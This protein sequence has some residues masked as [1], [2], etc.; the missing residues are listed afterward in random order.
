MPARFELLQAHG[1]NLAGGEAENLT[2]SAR[3]PDVKSRLADARTFLGQGDLL[4]GAR[5]LF[6]GDEGQITG[7]VAVKH[8]AL[9]SL[10]GGN[11]LDVLLL[12]RQ[13]GAIFEI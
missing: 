5:E 3:A 13:H 1:A 6:D 4:G 9:Q 2:H 11:P 7:L 12:I 10:T 8:S